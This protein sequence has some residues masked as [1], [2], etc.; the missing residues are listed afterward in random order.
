MR[1]IKRG[2]DASA[3]RSF[4]YFRLFCLSN[5]IVDLHPIVAGL[6]IRT[7]TTMDWGP[8]LQVKQILSEI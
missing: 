2:K 7:Y 6:I 5:L 3:N 1:I 8:E 4:S